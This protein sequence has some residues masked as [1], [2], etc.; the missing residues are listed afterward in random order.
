MIRV[1]FILLALI[2]VVLAFR[3]FKKQSAGKRWQALMLV[4]AVILLGLVA[5]GRMHWLFAL[6][7]A[8][9]PVMRRL[10]G[11]IGYLPMLRRVMGTLRGQ[12]Q[13]QTTNSTNNSTNLTV[14]EAY[15]ILDLPIGAS[16][17]DVIQ[18][19]K[20]LMQKMHP[21]RGGSSHL[22]TKINQAKDVLLKTTQ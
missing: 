9:L 3:W 22:A 8:A 6:V 17:E 2:S 18:A 4:T 19:H 12:P 11:L 14:E 5:T 7:G 15:A 1:V 13:S 10:L 20:Q 21:D 16:R